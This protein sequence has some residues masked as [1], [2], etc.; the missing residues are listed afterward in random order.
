MRLSNGPSANERH[1]S[2]KRSRSRSSER[3]TSW[4]PSGRKHSPTRK[5]GSSGHRMTPL[6]RQNSQSPRPSD[7]IKSSGKRRRNGDS[8][9]I[10]RQHNLGDASQSPV[11]SPWNER[12]KETPIL[13]MRDVKGK[14][15]ADEIEMTTSFDGAKLEIV[16]PNLIQLSVATEND[17]ELD[18][19]QNITPIGMVRVPRNRTL[20]ES[21]KAHLAVSGE[22][23]RQGP[24]PSLLTRLSDSPYVPPAN[25]TK[26]RNM[27][28]DC[29]QQNA[30][31]HDHARH[32]RKNLS[33]YDNSANTGSLGQQQL[34]Q[35][36]TSRSENC[37][38]K[39]QK[40]KPPTGS[41]NSH[42]SVNIINRSPARP[43]P[44]V[45]QNSV[46]TLTTVEDNTMTI[47]SY[48]RIPSRS[49]PVPSSSQSQVD[50]PNQFHDPQSGSSIAVGLNK[51]RPL[52]HSTSLNSVETRTRLLARLEIEKRQVV[53]A[54]VTD[55]NY[56]P[57][58][59]PSSFPSR[60]LGC[61]IPLKPHEDEEPDVLELASDSVVSEESRKRESKLRARAQLRVRLAAEKRDCLVDVD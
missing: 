11:A 25:S 7:N 56:S 37:A 61:D 38:T 44:V 60:P 17:N 12:E 5:M 8:E 23:A 46:T 27:S 13:T 49:L 50:P 16:E 9:H 35:P 52:A 45:R 3:S 14:R 59:S 6:S 47:P 40:E 55:T 42:V 19:T 33:H 24:V 53:Q 20:Q 30:G 28:G 39:A 32:S 10:G 15:K 34:R 43:R 31:D 1:R 41:K 22:S 2:Q 21:V 18:R 54:S 36:F 4:S 26:A 58:D 57:C 48:Q 51:S 29:C